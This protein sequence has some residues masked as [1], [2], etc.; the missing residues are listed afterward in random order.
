MFK[1]GYRVEGE[2]DYSVEIEDLVFTK[3]KGDVRR[4][5]TGARTSI[6]ARVHRYAF[7]IGCSSRWEE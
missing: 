6:L 4:V 7:R 3:Y 2:I 1:A 5:I